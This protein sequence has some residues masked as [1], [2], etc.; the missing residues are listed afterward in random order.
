VTT[1]SPSRTR[2][3]DRGAH[4]PLA[5]VAAALSLVVFGAGLVLSAGRIRSGPE[6]QA[7]LVITLEGAV[8]WVAG[9]TAFRRATRAPAALPFLFMSKSL[10]RDELRL[11][12]SLIP[13][14][15]AEAGTQFLWPN[16]PPLDSR[17]SRE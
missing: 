1:S 5:I 4:L 8:F 13:F 15:P 3:S 12:R 7:L 11:N 2:A 10:E 17:F 6:S 16:S 9:V 14:V